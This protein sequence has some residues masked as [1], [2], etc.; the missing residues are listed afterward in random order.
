MIKLRHP[1]I[2]E[3]YKYSVDETN[4]GTHI[5]MVMQRMQSD[6]TSYTFKDINDKIRV[7]KQIVQGLRMLHEELIVHRD[8]KPQN[9]LVDSKGDIRLADLGISAVSLI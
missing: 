8:L 9:I 3:L 6:L 1:R 5:Y 2:I 7:I 4:S